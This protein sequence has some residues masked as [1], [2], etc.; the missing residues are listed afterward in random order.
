MSTPHAV[1]RRREP[2]S[3]ITVFNDLDMRLACLDR[4]LEVHAAEAPDIEFI[5]V[6]NREGRFST[7]SA[8]LNHGASLARHDH[9]VFV[10]QDV[11][12]HSLVALEEAAGAL[13]DDEGIGLLGAIGPTADGRFFG[14]VRDRIFLLGDEASRPTS[15]DCVDEVLF[16]ISRRQLEAEPLLEDPELAWHAYAVE[17]GLR[18]RAQGKRVCVVDIPLSHNSLATNMD[19]LEHAYAAVAAHH[20]DEMPVV[21]PQ[22]KVEAGG[23]RRDRA[24]FLAD[25]RW[26]YRW[27]RE[28]VDAHAGRRAAAGTPCVLADVREDIDM[29]LEGIADDEPLL[30]ISADHQEGFADEHPGP[31]TLLRYGRPV[32]VTSAR[33]GALVA[34]V[35]AAGERP[36]VLTNLTIEDVRALTGH[37]PAGPRTLGYRTSIG[38]WMVLGVAPEAL[39]AEWRSPRSTPL[40]M[41]GLKA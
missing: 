18:M 34:A 33:P 28:S 9:F 4:S 17:Y 38:Y 25:H 26:R 21:T 31:L 10:H 27:L 39:P 3:V 2:V 7:A 15:V 19:R 35:T 11:Y 20:P 36:V 41:A 12:L 16:M 13:A 24:V 8:A 30:V 37:L 40:G 6:D 14:R 5:P 29:L 1:T 22:G 32:L 23:R